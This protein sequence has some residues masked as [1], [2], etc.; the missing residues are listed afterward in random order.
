MKKIF[1]LILI[2]LFAA[3]TSMNAQN[4][5]PTDNSEPRQNGARRP[6]L[7]M[8]LDLSPSQIQQIRRINA[9]VKLARR[10]A[11]QRLRE[12][13]RSLDLAIYADNADETE[14][15]TR[16]KEVHA[17]QNEVLKIRAETEYAVR[18][19]LT[20]EQLVRFR[21]IRQQF[22]ERMQNQPKQ[23]NVRPLN[24]PKRNLMNRI[25]RQQQ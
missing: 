4:I 12:A 21:E 24:A 3:F 20:A 17:A 1:P 19:V 10:D 7:L 8:E 14:I 2:A 23:P 15:Q 16:L 11:Q 22:L 9:D 5:Q 6:N 13:N 25:R 18:K